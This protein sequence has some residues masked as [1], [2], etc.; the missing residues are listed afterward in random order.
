MTSMQRLEQTVSLLSSAEPWDSAPPPEQMKAID[1]VLR[2]YFG[3]EDWV[4]E[5]NRALPGL[6]GP[7]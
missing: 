5:R 3:S 2:H 4:R 7:R 1:Q 6:A